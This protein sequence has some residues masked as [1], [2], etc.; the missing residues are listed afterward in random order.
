MAW[1]HAMSPSPLTMA[2]PRAEVQG[3]VRVQRGV[4]AAIDDE[5]AP[6]ASD[7]ADLVS[8][9]GVARVDADADDVARRDGGR[10][11]LL[12]GLVGDE[13]IAVFRGGGCR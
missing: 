12:E 9:Q 6:V 2:W 11:E 13:R 10:V 4:N 7:P 3:F 5:R 1:P 8:A